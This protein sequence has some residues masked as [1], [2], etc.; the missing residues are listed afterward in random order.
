MTPE[1]IELLKKHPEL[2]TRDECLYFINEHD[3][4]MVIIDGETWFKYSFEYAGPRIL[5]MS[6]YFY[7]RNDKEA[8]KIVRSIKQSSELNGRIIYSEGVDL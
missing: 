3:P 2:T 8:E 7:A 5:T 6:S 1:R 4:L